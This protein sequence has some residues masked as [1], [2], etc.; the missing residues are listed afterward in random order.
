MEIC[1]SDKIGHP[2]G[3]VWSKQM[4]ADKG[5]GRGSKNPKI[6][7]MPYVYGPLWKNKNLEFW[8][9]QP[10][11][12]VQTLHTDLVDGGRVEPGLLELSLDHDL[13]PHVDRR[14][15]E[16]IEEAQRGHLE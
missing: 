12:N 4:N 10:K 15:R 9:M 11:P 1:G 5:E 13:L 3:G 2:G 16:L 6:L 7:Q 8:F 14:L